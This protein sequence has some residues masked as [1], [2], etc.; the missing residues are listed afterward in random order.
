MQILKNKYIDSNQKII[1]NNKSKLK[2][3]NN[4]N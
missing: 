1:E 3:N 2:E 4:Y